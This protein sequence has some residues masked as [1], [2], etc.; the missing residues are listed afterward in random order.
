MT[1]TYFPGLN[2]LRFF[3]A[4]AV[5]V[6]HV[7]LTKKFMLHGDKFWLKIDTWIQGNAF[8]S[9]LRDGPPQPIH[10][11]SPF[12]T[13]GGYIGVIFFFVLSG[14]LITYLLL[15]EK[16][17]S[18]TVAV[19]K[20]YMRRILRIWPLYYFLVIMG[21]FVLHHIPLFEVIS[22]EDEFLKHY[23]LN[24]V[25][26][27]FLLP[28][29][30]FAYVMEA[31]PN[32]GHLWSIGVEEQFYLLWPLLL[33]YSRRPMRT[34]WGFLIGVLAFK[35]ISLLVI[36]LCF[37]GP[38]PDPDLMIFSPVETFKRFV[39]SLKF[40]AMAMGGIG[41]GWVFY[42]R[43]RILQLLY[44]KAAQWLALAAIPGIVLFTPV[45]LYSGL[46]LL[47]SVPFLIII[48]NVATNPNCVYRLQGRV[49]NYLGKISYGI[50]MYHLVCIAFAFH[51]L[52]S[53]IH[54]PLRLEGWHSA[55]LYALSIPLTLGVSA[56]SYHFLEYPFIRKKRTF[57]TVISG[58]DARD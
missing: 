44:H 28:N 5:M 2:A 33:K 11:I 30:S 14:F 20:F 27:V 45:K 55:L 18:D 1:K 16:R 56:L 41:A 12:V 9:I 47:F 50:Y 21:F 7:E 46:Y 4:M 48:V 36:R 29:F 54:F 51:L 22:Q 34:L 19:K 17:V 15:E 10:W 37:P 42:Q 52:D 23:W 24:L 40:E 43:K 25:S 49:L 6:T 8:S 13:F 35:L 32:L 26:Y 39:G 38:P 57:T 3:A 31:V 53:M 58:D